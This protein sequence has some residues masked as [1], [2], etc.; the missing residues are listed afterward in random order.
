MGHCTGKL[1]GAS[2]LT[3]YRLGFQ[4][5]AHNNEGTSSLPG[6]RL[7]GPRDRL[8]S[9]VSLEI[10]EMSGKEATKE[11]PQTPHFVSQDIASPVLQLISAKIFSY[12]AALC[13]H[14]YH[15]QPHLQYLYVLTRLVQQ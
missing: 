6:P 13:M 3:L 7:P 4:L 1:K 10:L 12:M 9:I 11:A 15:W 14:P 5:P 8:C 2:S